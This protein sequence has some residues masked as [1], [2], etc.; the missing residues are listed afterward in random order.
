MLSR[1]NWLTELVGYVLRGGL[2]DDPDWAFDAAGEMYREWSDLDPG[3]AADS[4]FSPEVLRGHS[5]ETVPCWR[6]RAELH[7]AESWQRHV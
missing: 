1:R 5:H 4:A 3:I 7:G 6:R 2:S